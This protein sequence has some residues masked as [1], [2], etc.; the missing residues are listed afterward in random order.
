MKN[1]KVQRIR[2]KVMMLKQQFLQGDTGVFAQVLGDQE[3]T[4]IMSKLG[5]PYRERIYSPLDT[6]R[7]FVGQVLSSDRACQDV[8]GRCL[9]ERIAQ[10]LRPSALNTGAYCDAR[11]RLPVALPVTLGTTLGERLEAMAPPAQA[12]GSRPRGL[13]S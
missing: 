6:L 13:D 12:A 2:Q 4:T 9:S 11:Q 3:I 8:V 1:T 7:L 10:G 5:I